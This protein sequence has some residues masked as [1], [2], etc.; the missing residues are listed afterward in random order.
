MNDQISVH[1]IGCGQASPFQT[2]PTPWCSACF[3][4]P[5]LVDYWNRLMNKAGDPMK[6][7]LWMKQKDGCDYTIGCGERL[8]E[9]S[10]STIQGARGQARIA[11]N[12]YGS[13]DR[14]LTQALI[15]S[16]VEDAMPIVEEMQKEQDEAEQQNELTKKRAQLARLKK[17]LGEE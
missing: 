4:E 14:K 5:R 17:E 11:L 16:V 13:N 9:L 2:L 3:G 7:Y 15:L 8:V 12:Y 1:C 6:F 10:P